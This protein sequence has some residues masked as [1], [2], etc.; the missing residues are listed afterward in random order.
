MNQHEIR[1]LKARLTRLEQLI[2]DMAI[3]ETTRSG[4]APIEDGPTG[5][6]THP[7]TSVS[8]QPHRSA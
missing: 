2:A 3:P 8:G 7:A 1:T 5:S 6:E 4:S